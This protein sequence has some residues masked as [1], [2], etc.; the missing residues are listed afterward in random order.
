MVLFYKTALFFILYSMTNERLTIYLKEV[1]SIFKPA[2]NQVYISC[3]NIK[4]TF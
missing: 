4:F 3:E 1:K 2:K